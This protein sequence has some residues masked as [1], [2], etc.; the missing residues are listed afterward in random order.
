MLASTFACDHD[1][2]HDEEEKSREGELSKA[3]DDTKKSTNTS[4]LLEYFY[5]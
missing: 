2:D 3:S 1:E 4:V 5:Q